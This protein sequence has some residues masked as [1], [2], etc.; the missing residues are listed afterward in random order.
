M[1]K[2]AVIIS[3]GFEEIEGIT[4]IDILRRAGIDVVMLGVDSRRIT[5]AHGIEVVCDQT[6]SEYKDLPD[7]LII[8]GGMPGATNIAESQAASELIMNTYSKG[9]LVAAICASPGVVLAPLGLLE[10][11]EFSCYPGFEDRVINGISSEKSVVVADNII[12]SK[13]PGTAIGFALEIVE[14]LLDRNSAETI[15]RALLFPRTF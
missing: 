8:P 5:G 11:R 9:N 3:P 13:G 4:P 12:T 10:N 6:V 14:Y 1:R 15:S 7:A 2:A